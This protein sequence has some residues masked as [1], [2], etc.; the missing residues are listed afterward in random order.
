MNRAM[1]LAS[2]KRSPDYLTSTSDR[3]LL[4]IT[5]NRNSEISK[6]MVLECECVSFSLSL[7]P[8]RRVQI[9]TVIVIL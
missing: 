3:E 9:L 4:R 7:L 1:N 6:N 8:R 2:R 5:T